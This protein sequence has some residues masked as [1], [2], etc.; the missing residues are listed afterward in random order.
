MSSIS[1]LFTRNMLKANYAHTKRN[2][3]NIYIHTY[4]YNPIPPIIIHK[5]NLAKFKPYTHR[6]A[7]K[8]YYHDLRNFEHRKALIN[9]KIEKVK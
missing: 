4:R 2:K 3:K 6:N 9:F 8:I 7:E 1:T 5:E